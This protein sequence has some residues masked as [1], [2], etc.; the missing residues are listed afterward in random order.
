MKSLLTR[1]II[2]VSL[3]LFFFIIGLLLLLS[4]QKEFNF[5]IFLVLKLLGLL[6]VVASLYVTGVI[7]KDEINNL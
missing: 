3:L 2:V 6:F 5:I 7:F 1:Q 4:E